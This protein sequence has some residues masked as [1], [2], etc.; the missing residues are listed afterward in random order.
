MPNP[1]GNKGLPTEE[2]AKIIKLHQEGKSHFEICKTTNHALTTILNVLKSYE[3]FEDE[4][5][6]VSAEKRRKIQESD[7]PKIMK[8]YNEGRK[9]KE[10]CAEIGVT[11]IPLRKFLA[12]E[13]IY[14]PIYKKRLTDF[15]KED[16]QRIQHAIDDSDTLALAARKSGST[17]YVLR[18][19]IN[20]GILRHNPKHTKF[21]LNQNLFIKSLDIYLKISSDKNKPL[22]KKLEIVKN[23]DNEFDVYI[24]LKNVNKIFKNYEDITDI[25][26]GKVEI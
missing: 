25:I 24:S 5:H 21:V 6:V 11:Y 1:Y 12:K 20:K 19:L 15:S 7:K 16:I 17:Q 26:N 13:G 10:I 18:Y 23:Q 8:M 2:I 22:I 9:L 4:R 14:V 3:S